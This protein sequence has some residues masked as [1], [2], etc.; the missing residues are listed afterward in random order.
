MASPIQAS[1]ILLRRTLFLSLAPSTMH[2]LP[3]E[4]GL[5]MPAEWEP[6]EATWIAWPHRREDWPGK[7]AAI[8]WVYCEIVRYLHTG[9]RVHIIVNDDAAE[10]RARRTLRRAGIDLEQVLFFHF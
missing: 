4:L 8:G 6:H 1:P 2:S 7:F 10:Q 9:E 3:A 5:R